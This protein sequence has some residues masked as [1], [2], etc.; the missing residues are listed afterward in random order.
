[1][2]YKYCNIRKHTITLKTSCI[3]SQMQLKEDWLT[4]LIPTMV[5]TCMHVYTCYDWYIMFSV[6]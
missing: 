6:R 3:S 5:C 4:V 1:M 2:Q